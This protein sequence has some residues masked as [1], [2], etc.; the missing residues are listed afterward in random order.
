[1]DAGDD[2]ADTSLDAGLL[3][4]FSDVLACFADDDPSILG[5][6]E[7]TESQGVVP[8]GR[9]RTRLRGRA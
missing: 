6:H 9:G 4:E 5:A 7:S 3:P 8:V 1:M 2:F